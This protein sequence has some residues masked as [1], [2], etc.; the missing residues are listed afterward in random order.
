MSTKSTILLTNDKNEHWYHD[1]ID[2][3][4]II[5]INRNEFTSVDDMEEDVVIEIKEGS[6]LHKKMEKLMAMA[7]EGRLKI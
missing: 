6:E 3:S 4:F 5:E 7:I 1:C 2:N